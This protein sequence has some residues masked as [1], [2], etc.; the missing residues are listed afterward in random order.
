MKK[1]V[2]LLSALFLILSLASCDSDDP[3]TPTDTDSIE[4]TAP[5]TERTLISADTGTDYV[6]VRADTDGGTAALTLSQSV[7]S[8][9]EEATGT[10]PALKTDWYKNGMGTV[11][12]A[13]EILIGETN[14]DES[15]LLAESW[16]ANGLY[17]WTVRLV[18]EKILIY[19]GSDDALASA[20]SYFEENCIRDGAVVMAE[21]FSY[22]YE[23]AWPLNAMRIGENDISLYQIVVA[24]DADSSVTAAAE[25]IRRFVRENVG[26]SL[27]ILKDG[28][29]KKKTDYEIVLG[30]TNRAATLPDAMQYVVQDES[31][32]FVGGTTEIALYSAVAALTNAQAGTTE[33]GVYT[34]T[35]T[36]TTDESDLMESGVIDLLKSYVENR[37][38]LGRKK[39]LKQLMTYENLTDLGD[40]DVYGNYA[41]PALYMPDDEITAEELAFANK[42]IRKVAGYMTTDIPPSK[43]D[44]VRGEVDFAANRLVRA[45]Y[46]PEGR[47]EDE[48][49]AALQRF[50]LNDDFFSIYTGENHSLMSHT[51]RYL[52]ACYYEGETFTQYKKTAAEL[53]EED[54]EWLKEFMRFRA[55]Q[56]WAEFDSMGYAIEDLLSLLNLYDCS[57]DEE[58]RTLAKMS[59]DTILMSMIVDCTENGIYGGAHA[60]SYDITT[61]SLHNRIYWIYYLYFGDTSFSDVE[62]FANYGKDINLPFAFFSDYRPDDILYAIVA[63]KTYPYSSY[64]RNHNITE[65]LDNIGDGWAN[66]YTYNTALYSIGCL[67]YQDAWEIGSRYQH[68]EDTQQTSWLLGFAENAKATI[69]VHHPGDTSYHGY[70]YGDS[71]CNC[72]HLFGHKNAVMG[73]FYIPGASQPYKFIHAYLD[74]SQFDEVIEQPEENRIFVRLGDA[75]AVLRF[76]ESYSWN[77]SAEI[78]VYDGDKKSDIRIAM[79]CEAGDREE[80]GSFD[81]FVAAME[82]KNFSFDKEGLTLEYGNMRLDITRY[83]KRDGVIETQY[84]DGVPVEYPYD[85]TYDS[86]Y[87]KSVWDSGVIE[88]YYKNYVRVMDYIKSS[89]TLSRND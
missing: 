34:V 44:N 59:M 71:Q 72:N 67:N 69:T 86:P 7:R 52:A 22:T 25:A 29:V 70:W 43:K 27:S 18:G 1:R 5:A 75:Y 15:A 63:D 28:V 64:E 60:R 32:L 74:R 4:T 13:H 66:H 85:Y 17:D 51:A 19:G 2:A 49:A 87:M 10:A 36:Y 20:V 48:S 3:K 23:H 38:A 30:D 12:Q 6:I 41:V 16:R 40:V 76:S 78:L 11:P 45:L 62:G 42:V 57:E 46:A 80:Y 31:R 79:A 47:L 68:I 35:G 81:A 24:S 53:I 9:I 54:G 73:I 37:A 77:G 21:D 14:R 84:L 88:V 61:I 89:D 82:E 8:A 50:F 65:Q 33:N 55:R 26:V 83:N 58:I 39:Q 56:G